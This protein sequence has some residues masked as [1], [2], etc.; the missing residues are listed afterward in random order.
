MNTFR[1]HNF[2][3][4]IVIVGIDNH[5]FCIRPTLGGILD[6]IETYINQFLVEQLK[7]YLLHKKLDTQFRN[8]TF[9]RHLY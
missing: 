9:D 5:L 8:W 1:W 6:I 3:Q 7:L 2:V 4:E